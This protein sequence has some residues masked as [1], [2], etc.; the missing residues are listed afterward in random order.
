[1]PEAGEMVPAKGRGERDPRDG[2]DMKTA[3]GVGSMVARV[4]LVSNNSDDVK[5]RV[6]R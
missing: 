6:S 2:R 4:L 5:I 3:E 1:M